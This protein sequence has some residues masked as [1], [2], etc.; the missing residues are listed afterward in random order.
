MRT[1]HQVVIPLER[2]WAGWLGLQAEKLSRG[3]KWI[4][5][6][7]FVLFAG[8]WTVY[9]VAGSFSGKSAISYPS[10]QMKSI[11][12]LPAPKGGLRRMGPLLSK[13]EYGRIHRFSLYIDSQKAT[14]CG[15][16]LLDSITGNR[17]GLL[18][19]LRLVENLYQSQIKPR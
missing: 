2:S 10:L 3:G 13:E 18:D 12:A 1:L 8:G 15:R 16:R 14:A 6:A 17:P 7:L 4:F 5:L 19:S 9:L 11:P